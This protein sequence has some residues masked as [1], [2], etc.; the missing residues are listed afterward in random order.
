MDV[1]SQ[2]SLSLHIRSTKLKLKLPSIKKVDV[3]EGIDDGIIKMMGNGMD[4]NKIRVCY[5]EVAS[6]NGKEHDINSNKN[7]DNDNTNIFSY[8]NEKHKSNK[9]DEKNYKNT[10]ECVENDK[11]E[12][13]QVHKENC[14]NNLYYLQEH[15]PGDTAPLPLKDLREEFQK[16][17]TLGLNNGNV[18]HIKYSYS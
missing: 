17:S 14:N 7:S 1:S 5:V 12:G 6:T 13:T 15:R 3:E 11:Y 2:K 8:V 18:I 4:E 9:L 10:I 16:S